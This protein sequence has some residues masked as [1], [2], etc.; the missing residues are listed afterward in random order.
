MSKTEYDEI[1]ANLIKKSLE[2]NK[3]DLYIPVERRKRIDGRL[4]FVNLVSFLCWVALFVACVTIVKSGK[5]LKYINENDL[6][7]LPGEFWK[8]EWLYGALCITVLCMLICFISIILNFTRNRRRS[9]RIR[10]SLVFAEIIS[11][12]IGAFLIIKLF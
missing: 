12:F 6:L 10:K 9:D 1:K 11:F 7:W 2:R 5:S 8:E 4:S 3:K